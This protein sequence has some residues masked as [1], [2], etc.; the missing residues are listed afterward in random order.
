M[1][2]V[3]RPRCW[4]EFVFHDLCRSLAQGNIVRIDSDS[5]TEREYQIAIYGAYGDQVLYSP[6][7]DGYT[8][9]YQ[10]VRA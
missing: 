8:Y 9:A 5:R 7:Q 6:C 1:T 3:Y 4:S 10:L 2:Q